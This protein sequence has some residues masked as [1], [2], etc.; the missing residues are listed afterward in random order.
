M[1]RLSIVF[2]FSDCFIC[3][4]SSL[5]LAIDNSPSF[6]FCTS[7]WALNESLGQVVQSSDLDTSY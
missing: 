5:T 3:E 1:D 2:L 6:P 4:N 7:P